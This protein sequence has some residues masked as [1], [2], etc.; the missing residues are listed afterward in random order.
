[1]K[2]NIL[3]A[4]FAGILGTIAITIVASM[5]APLMGFPKMDIPGMLAGV[6]GG[7]VLFGWFAHFMVG[8]V[9]AVGYALV[10][11]QLPGP[12]AI[13]GALYGWAPWLVAQ[14]AVMPMMGMGFFSGAFSPALGSLM[15]HLV[16]G[17]VVG[18]VYS[19]GSRSISPCE[20]KRTTCGC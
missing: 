13:R 7:V 18:L 8:M 11:G 1:M 9:L 17:A 6:M 15:G 19:N 3:K 5:G 12:A 14:I 10:Q 2:I 4:I 20:P 16:Y